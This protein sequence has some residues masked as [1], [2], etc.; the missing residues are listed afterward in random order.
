M[1]KAVFRLRKGDQEVEQIWLHD[2]DRVDLNAYARMLLQARSGALGLKR[3]SCDIWL[4]LPSGSMAYAGTE[5]TRTS[6][7]EEAQCGR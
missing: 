3:L 6:T 2:L 5:C 4:R 7:K 1:M